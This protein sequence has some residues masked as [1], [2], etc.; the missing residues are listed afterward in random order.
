MPCYGA[1]SAVP[2]WH[3]MVESEDIVEKE[4]N[5]GSRNNGGGSKGRGKVPVECYIGAKDGQEGKSMA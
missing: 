3:P 2:A 5:A 4:A 1:W